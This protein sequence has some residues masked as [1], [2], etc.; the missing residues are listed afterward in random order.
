[1][2]NRLKL[3]TAEKST[4]NYVPYITNGESD[5]YGGVFPALIYK[6][7]NVY[8]TLDKGG[9]E[10]MGLVTCSYLKN[11][12]DKYMFKGTKY[13]ASIYN[14]TLYYLFPGN[15]ANDNL[16]NTENNRNI[17]KAIIKQTRANNIII[18]ICYKW[19]K[20]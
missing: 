8:Y 3:V 18:L 9:S 2:S 4:E 1:M 15:S 13:I 14:P 6:N 17:R 19:I 5:V 10:K 12:L 7:G 16:F 20:E 11:V